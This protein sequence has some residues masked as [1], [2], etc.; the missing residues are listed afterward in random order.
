MPPVTGVQGIEKPSHHT[1]KFD[2]TNAPFADRRV[3]GWCLFQAFLNDDD[4][5]LDEDW[6]DGRPSGV[7]AGAEGS[8]FC[9]AHG[10]EETKTKFSC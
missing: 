9:R 4:A 5:D 6:K 8:W 2:H 1:T 10:P 3:H 7:K